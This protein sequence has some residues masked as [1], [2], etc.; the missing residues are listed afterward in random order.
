MK[1]NF[2]S[3]LVGILHMGVGMVNN[4][5][6]F[7][8]LLFCHRFLLHTSSKLAGL[9][10][11]TYLNYKRA[12]WTKYTNNES[13]EGFPDVATVEKEQLI[14]DLYNRFYQAIN[15]S[16]P[17]SRTTKYIPKP[18]WTNELILSKAKRE[19]L[20]QNYRRNKTI[21]NLFKF[22]ILSF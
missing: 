12:D 20:Y 1:L 18:W 8:T 13:S 6:Y 22:L 17:T 10:N 4:G 7:F 19:R 2:T 5:D 16:I 15:N 9:T 14:I 11:L 3:I 21:H